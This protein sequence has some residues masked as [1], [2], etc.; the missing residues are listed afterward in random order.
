MKKFLAS[1]A[2]IGLCASCGGTSAVTFE[3]VRQE[4]VRL[5]DQFDNFEPTPDTELPQ[6]GST[7]YQ[8]AALAVVLNSSGGPNST[9]FLA[10]GRSRVTAN[11]DSGTLSSVSN[12]FFEITNVPSDLS[13][14]RL[15]DDPE[16][17]AIA[18]EVRISLRQTIPG[19]NS[20]EGGSSGSLSSL[21]G[22]IIDFDISS[23]ANGLLGG[24]NGEAATLATARGDRGIVTGMVVV[25]D[26]P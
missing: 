19:A 12:N 10:V 25:A 26:K 20:F 2:T 14:P 11:F 7:T 17:E 15:N 1:L 22:A 24:E 23:S 6:S 3:E 8:G 5:D 16:G 9:E 21:S 18:G 13:A 4:F